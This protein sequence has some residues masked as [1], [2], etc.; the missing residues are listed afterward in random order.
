VR[1]SVDA[2]AVSYLD[3][4]S[5]SGP[6]EWHLLKPRLSPQ[7][8]SN[9]WEVSSHET[10][11]LSSRPFE[12]MRKAINS[13]IFNKIG[14]VL[15]ARHGKLVSEDYFEGSR[16]T[17]RQT[18]STTKSITSILVGIA[19]DKGYLSGVDALVTPFFPDKQPLKNPDPRKERITVEDFLT[20]SS[21]LE[22]DDNN[23]F[24][25]GHEERMY[26]I[27][28]YVKF[29]LDLPI[30]GFPSWATRPEDSP[31]GRSFSYC[32][33]GTA[34]LGGVLERATKMP[35]PEFAKKFLFEPMGINQAEWPPT[36]SG[37]VFTGGG[38]GL[39]SQDLLK[40]G[41]LY[42][43][44]GRW[45]GAQIVS[46]AWVQTS[47]RPHVHV[48]E[49]DYVKET[50]YGYLWWLKSFESHG[51]KFPSFNMLGNGGNKVSVFPTLDMVVTITSTNYNN[52]GAHQQT[53]QLLSDYILAAVAQ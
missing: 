8:E 44:E 7:E 50:D 25:R 46:K 39:E 10:V 9:A 40:L 11:G 24:S 31:F 23:L 30:R 35:V 21:L 14:S 12:A 33:A 5:S 49:T 19:I 43:N 4:S 42:L 47:I 13:G 26:L 20:M 53:D 45:R 28:D 37:L 36:P 22:C 2:F 16:S 34:T 29:T 27:E 17:L 48:D 1:K 15:V 52:R 38:L 6:F 41:Q 51:K 18:R 3:I 32:T